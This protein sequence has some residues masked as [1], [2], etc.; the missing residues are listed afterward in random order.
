MSCRTVSEGHLTETLRSVC[1]LR[2]AGT[3]ASR[4]GAMSFRLRKRNRRGVRRAGPVRAAGRPLGKTAALRSWGVSSPV[5][6]HRAT[7]R[8]GSLLLAILVVALLTAGLHVLF[9]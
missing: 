4:G 3:T 7:P 9:Q 8:L 1:E 2:N 5:A 6:T